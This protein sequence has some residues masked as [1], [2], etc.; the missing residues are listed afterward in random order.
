MPAVK[1]TAP[2][3]PFFLNPSI[4]SE[5]PRTTSWER[6]CPLGLSCPTKLLARC[7][8]SWRKTKEED[9]WDFVS[10]NEWGH[11]TQISSDSSS[12]LLHK[13]LNDLLQTVRGYC[14]GTECHPIKKKNPLN[15][16][17]HGQWIALKRCNSE[18]VKSQSLWDT[19][20]PVDTNTLMIVWK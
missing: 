18:D 17:Q 1:K 19:P 4:R 14:L 7:L 3:S 15:N 16:G 20:R 9:S 5:L 12:G 8:P 13:W 11:L 2:I 6:P 10:S